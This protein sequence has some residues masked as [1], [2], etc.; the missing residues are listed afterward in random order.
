MPAKTLRPKGQKARERIGE[1][2]CAENSFEHTESPTVLVQGAEKFFVQSYG[3]AVALLRELLVNGL[4]IVNPLLGI[5]C[6]WQSADSSFCRCVVA[7]PRD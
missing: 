2:F 3:L 6:Q 4:I 5:F 7:L 1:K